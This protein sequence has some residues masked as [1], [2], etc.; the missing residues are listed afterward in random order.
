MSFTRW[1]S[2]FLRQCDLIFLANPTRSGHERIAAVEY[3]QSEEKNAQRY[4][5]KCQWR[6]KAPR[7]FPRKISS[8]FKA[9]ANRSAVEKALC[10]F[11]RA[12]FCVIFNDSWEICD[13]VFLGF[14]ENVM[15]HNK[16]ITCLNWLAHLFPCMSWAVQP[17]KA[18]VFIPQS[19]RDNENKSEA[20]NEFRSGDGG[21]FQSWKFQVKTHNSSFSTL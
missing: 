15:L 11:F 8:I 9:F 6:Q 2:S 3:L 13:S 1:P 5:V 21:I 20:R 19:V 14:Q 10:V 12:L 18:K 16:T 4:R 7:K 17:M